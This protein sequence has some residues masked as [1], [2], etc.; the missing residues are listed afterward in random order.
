MLSYTFSK[1]KFINTKLRDYCLES[2]LLSISK[3]NIKNDKYNKYFQNIKYDSS[4]NKIGGI[5]ITSNDSKENPLINPC[6]Y[7]FVIIGISSYLYR[8]YNSQK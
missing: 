5:L 8:F 3:K 2:T 1:G 6:I 7:I 4:E